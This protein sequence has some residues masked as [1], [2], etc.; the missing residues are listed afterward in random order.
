MSN[1]CSSPSSSPAAAPC[2]NQHHQHLHQNHNHHKPSSPS[3][4]SSSSSFPASPLDAANTN[5][6][7]IWPNTHPHSPQ[8][9]S[10]KRA[11]AHSSSL[12]SPLASLLNE[13]ALATAAMAVEHS[14]DHMY[15]FLPNV[16]KRVEIRENLES[17]VAQLCKNRARTACSGRRGLFDEQKNT[18]AGLPL[19]SSAATKNASAEPTATTFATR[20]IFDTSML[21]NEETNSALI[22]FCQKTTPRTPD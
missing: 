21:L 14:V 1:S 2:I 16:Y 4:A 18:A 11:S 6:I 8:K 3:S 7:T 5:G 15:L 12:P 19:R 22:G 20:N 9:Q 13:T 10:T 17:S